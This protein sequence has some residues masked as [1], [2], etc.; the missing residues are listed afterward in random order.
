MKRG[1]VLELSNP[2]L[3]LLL[4]IFVVFFRWTIWRVG[5]FEISNADFFL[6]IFFLTSFYNLLK[7]KRSIKLDWNVLFLIFLIFFATLPLFYISQK[8]SHL[9]T[10][11]PFVLEVAFFLMVINTL[12]TEDRLKKAILFL[13]LGAGFSG[14]F[15][16]IQALSYIFFGIDWPGLTR[17]RGIITFEPV[18]AGT[19][20]WHVV[21]GFYLSLGLPSMLYFLIKGHPF[22]KR[23]LILPLFIS[24]LGGI[25]LSFSRGAW[26]ASFF[27]GLVIIAFI[28]IPHMRSLTFL[29]CLLLVSILV[30]IFREKVYSFFLFLINLNYE[31]VAVRFSRWVEALKIFKG[32][33]FTGVGF[34][35]LGV[36]L[37]N[38]YLEVLT[39]TGILG[40][41]FFFLFLLRTLKMSTIDPLKHL[42]YPISPIVLSLAGSFITVLVICLIM[43]GLS[44]RGLW[45]IFSLLNSAIFLLREKVKS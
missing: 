17:T 1:L 32:A 3:W 45:I 7:R 44:R 33:P 29:L 34:R 16:I 30:L 38:L 26:V 43:S 11:L 15:G 39:G 8:K 10:Y 42:Q 36:D 24:S 6:A 9:R 18:V 4:Y 5:E 19:F 22:F 28:L 35:T 23:K 41:S 25:F 12:N 31:S 40:F 21:Y 20:R 27:G 37:H 2:L 14:L 13:W